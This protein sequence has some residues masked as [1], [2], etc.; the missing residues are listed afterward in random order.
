VAEPPIKKLQKF[1]NFVIRRL[2]PLVRETYRNQPEKLPGWVAI[3]DDYKDLDD[4][5]GENT[6]ADIESS[7]V[8]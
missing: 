7:E 4:E 8:S 3:M 5:D 6:R 2:D 1:G